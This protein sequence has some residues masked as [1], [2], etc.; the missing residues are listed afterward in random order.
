MASNL[1]MR[2]IGTVFLPYISLI[3]LACNNSKISNQEIEIKAEKIIQKLNKNN[4]DIFRNWQFEYR[5]EGEI[6]TKS[7]KNRTD[8]KA[9]YFNKKDSASIMIFARFLNSPEYP[10]SIQ[11]DTAKFE[12]NFWFTKY[13]DGKIKIRSTT[14]S[15][16]DTILG[17]NYS[18]QTVFTKKIRLMN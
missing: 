5:G 4:F 6:W 12:S 9:Y 17:D 11:I 14:K 3:L 7:K 13:T 1:K 15:G 16:A 2:T 8:Y 18:E 10:C